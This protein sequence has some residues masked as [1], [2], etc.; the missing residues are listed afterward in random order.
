MLGR[1]NLP[2]FNTVGYKYIHVSGFSHSI[3]VGYPV[4]IIIV[5]VGH[6]RPDTK[7]AKGS[8]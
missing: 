4:A 8:R 7:G 3:F 6:L 5:L 1:S 2:F